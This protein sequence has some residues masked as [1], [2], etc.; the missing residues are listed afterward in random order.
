MNMGRFICAVLL[1]VLALTASAIEQV[2]TRVDLIETRGV[3]S[4]LFLNNPYDAGDWGFIGLCPEYSFV[5]AF[6]I[7]FVP[8]GNVDETAINAVK[9]YCSTEQHFDVGYVESAAG[10]DGLWYGMKVCHGTFI[11][12]FRAKVLE[13]QGVFTDDVAVQDFQAECNYGEEIL[14]GISLLDEEDATPVEFN[15]GEWSVWAQCPP[16]NAVC[17]LQTR[18]EAPQLADDDTAVTDINLFCCP[19]SPANSTMYNRY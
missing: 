17:G 4:T 19:R 8:P 12:G 16:G 6:E 5:H 15:D 9:L 13:Y 7:L 18:V 10:P 11:T 2:G 3:T 14:S 1:S